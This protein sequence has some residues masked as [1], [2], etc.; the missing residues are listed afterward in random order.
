MNV[1]LD[2]HVALWWYTD[3]QLL[4]K[5]SQNILADL[6]NTIFFSAAS[7][8]ELHL[9]ISIG[10]L[11]VSSDFM[12]KVIEDFTE[13]PIRS[14]HATRLQKINLLHRDPFDLMLIAQSIEDDL[15]LLTRDK[16]I[17]QYQIQCLEA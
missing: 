3:P 7:M 17:L 8:W 15:I 2:T 5:V 16:Q 10:K 9:K 11:K 4:N 12:E 6:D 13:L 1:L 14:R